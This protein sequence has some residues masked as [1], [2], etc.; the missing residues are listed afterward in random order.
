MSVKIENYKLLSLIGLI[1]IIA[2]SVMFG[3]TLGIEKA[4]LSIR[5]G[6]YSDSIYEAQKELN[7]ATTKIQAGDL[8]IQE[9]I[10][11]AKSEIYK[12]KLWSE[13]FIGIDSRY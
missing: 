1:I 13:N 7:L 6:P 12:I 2:I 10:N 8:K 4:K 3:Y 5:A 11:N 9:H